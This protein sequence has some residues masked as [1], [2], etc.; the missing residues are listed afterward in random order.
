MDN[1]RIRAESLV[2]TSQLGYAVNLTLPLLD[3]REQQR[4][5]EDILRRL[6][7]VHVAAACAYGFNR[8]QALEWI[9]QENL[10]SELT[11]SESKF[12]EKG[13]GD[14]HRFQLQVEGMWALAWALG[15]FSELDFSQD[16]DS[17]FVTTLPNLKTLENSSAIREK[18]KPQSFD[19]I[20]KK[21]DLAYCINWAV[22][23][24]LLSNR[25]LTGKPQA[26]VFSERWKALQWL[27]EVDE[28]DDIS[29]DT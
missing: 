14:R 12:I 27:T 8:A 28:W 9:S 2:I 1:K 22:R 7:C 13:I 6:L 23:Q 19:E 5:I 20:V 11:P 25:K 15:L 10:L 26:Y 17:K 3:I 16:C 29:I 4:S 18:V 21:C 24:H